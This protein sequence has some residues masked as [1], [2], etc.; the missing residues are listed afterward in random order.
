MVDKKRTSRRYVV[1][2]SNKGNEASLE[3]NKLYPA[4]AGPD[5][6]TKP[7]TADGYS[8]HQ[9]QAARGA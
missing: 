3:R 6:M 1:C 2:I 8:L 9:L 5:V 4:P 7:T